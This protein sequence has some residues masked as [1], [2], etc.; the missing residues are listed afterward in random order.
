[1]KHTLF[2]RK[3]TSSLV[4][5]SLVLSGTSVLNA[6]T[7]SFSRAVPVAENMQPAIPRPDQDAAVQA[8]LAALE[9]RTGK[10]PNIVILLVDD[11]G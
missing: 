3:M 6:E 5:M 8:K 1:M 4:A 10:K 11:M 9:A 2:G 7:A